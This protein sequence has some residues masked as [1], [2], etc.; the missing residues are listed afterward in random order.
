MY[1]NQIFILRIIYIPYQIQSIIKYEN[2]LIRCLFVD[3]CPGV[4]NHL[5]LKVRKANRFKL[6]FLHSTC[7][8]TCR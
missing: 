2:L 8:N 6:N 1:V 7:V 4:V 5:E 3:V